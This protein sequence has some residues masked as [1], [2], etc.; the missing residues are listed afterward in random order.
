MNKLDTTWNWSFNTPCKSLKD[1]LVLFEG[2]QPY[3]RDSGKF[4]SPKIQKVSVII[5]GRPNQLYAQGMR[6]FEQYDEICKY[7]AEG[8]QKDNN[9]DEVQKRLQLHNVN[10]G[11]YLTDKYA[12]WLDFRTTDENSLHGTGRRIENASEGITLQIEKKGEKSAGALNVYI[13]LIIDA[14][15]NIQSGAYVSA[16]Y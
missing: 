5:E 9:A 16:I 12:L 4:Y 1:I 14:Q 11:E 15:L 10:V 3:A 7:F 6:S 13:Y 2:E 8:S